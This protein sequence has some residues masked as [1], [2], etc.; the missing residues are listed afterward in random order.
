MR[1]NWDEAKH[2]RRFYGLAILGIS[3]VLDTA[4]VADAAGAAQT[5]VDGGIT[6]LEAAGGLWATW[7]A[8]MAKRPLVTGD[9]TLESASRYKGG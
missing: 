6:V 9:A 2:S 5:L 7:G 1:F 4:G 8:I 3:A